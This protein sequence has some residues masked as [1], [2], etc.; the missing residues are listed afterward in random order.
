MAAG[1]TLLQALLVLLNLLGLAVLSSPLTARWY[2]GAV[3]MV[4]AL[5]LVI[6]L[7]VA[8]R[9]LAPLLV[10]LA[11]AVALA[12]APW[13]VGASPRTGWSGHRDGAPESPPVTSTRYSGS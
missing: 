13:L 4:T 10:A 1:S 6:A 7:I 2:G 8:E 5:F 12:S 9:R 3:A 11:G